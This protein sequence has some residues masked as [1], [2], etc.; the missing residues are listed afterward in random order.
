MIASL[1]RISF[2]MTIARL[3]GISMPVVDLLWMAHAAPAHLP[4][5]LVGVQWS[6][7]GV[8]A[9]GSVGIAVMT[10]IPRCTPVRRASWLPAIMLISI[11]L[12][13]LIALGTSLLALLPSASMRSAWIILIL[14]VGMIPLVIYS[15]LAAFLGC[16]S[17]PT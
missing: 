16:E 17:G 1:A 6:Q 4:A 8:V 5:F 3:L 14:S 7:I 15:A 13:V 10:V 11:T 9:C 12:G 2:S